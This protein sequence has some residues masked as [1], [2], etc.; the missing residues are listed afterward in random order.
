MDTANDQNVHVEKARD[1]I[2]R[3]AGG[4]WQLAI[5]RDSVTPETSMARSCFRNGGFMN[6]RV[7]S[8]EIVWLYAF[9]MSLL[10]LHEGLR[11]GMIEYNQFLI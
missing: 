7:F 2:V 1:K 5:D 3:R 4:R 8:L 10:W 6:V 9:A 11:I